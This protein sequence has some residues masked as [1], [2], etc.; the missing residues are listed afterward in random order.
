MNHVIIFHASFNDK[1]LLL[2]IKDKYFILIKSKTFEMFM[3]ENKRVSLISQEIS[4][5]YSGIISD[6]NAL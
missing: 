2:I 6:Y 4:G 3:F 1:I 5:K